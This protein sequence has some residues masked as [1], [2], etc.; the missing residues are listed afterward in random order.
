MGLLILL[1]V[2]ADSASVW[3]CLWV[4]Q[5]GRFCSVSCF[6][7]GPADWPG[8]YFWRSRWTERQSVKAWNSHIHHWI[9]DLL[10]KCKFIRKRMVVIMMNWCF[11]IVVLEKTLE[12]PLDYKIKPVNPKGN[13]PQIFFGRMLLKLKLQHFG[14]LMWTA[15]SLEETPMPGKIEGKRRRQSQGMRWL[16]GVT[17]SMDMSLSKLWEILKDLR[18]CML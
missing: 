10:E 9:V 2:T 15:N 11:P 7:P 13:Q 16:D 5:L 17:D 4:P 8:K 3:V 18:A 1:W 6:P 12:S 14:H